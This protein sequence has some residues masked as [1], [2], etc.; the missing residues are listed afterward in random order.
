MSKLFERLVAARGLDEAFLSPKYE[1]CLDPYLL[2]QMREAVERIKFAVKNHEKCLIYGDYDVDGVT[3]STVLYDALRLAGIDDIEIMLPNRFVDGYGMSIKVV[4]RAI[5]DGAKLVLTVDCGSRNHDIVA[6]LRKN[7][8]DVVV[9]DHHECEETLPDALAVVNPK[10]KDAEKYVKMALEGSN[11]ASK[12]FMIKKAVGELRELA[13]AGVAFKI[14]QALMQE[15][16]IPEGQEKWLLDLATIGTIC[17]S[18]ILQGE[19]RRICKYGM[20]VLE[21]TRR[22]GLKE[23]MMRAGVKK[24][25]SD[26]IGYQ[27]GPRLNAA[28]RMDTAEKA[29]NLLMSKRRAEA[30]LLATELENLNDQRKHQQDSAVKEIAVRGVGENPVIIEQGDWHEGVLGIIAGRLVEEYHRPAFVLGVNSGELK[31]SGRSFGD[32]SLAEALE[33]C[34]GQIIGGGGHAAAC[35]LR[36]KMEQLDGFRA[37][38][39]D[40]YRSLNLKNQER[41]LEAREDVSVGNFED[42]SLELMD[43]IRLLEPFGEGNMMPIFRLPGVR[44]MEVARL[45]AGKQHLRL[46]LWDQFDHGLKVMKFSAPEDYLRLCP[47]DVVDAWV[48]L[49]ENVFRGI[50]SVEGRIVR[51]VW[52]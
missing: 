37:A 23:L 31:G 52:N 5:S 40:Y 13:G 35:G 28:G 7:G 45:G 46:L 14:A 48:T 1:E 19:N 22:P 32:F 41:Y 18:M 33:A 11:L 29:L 42:F 27:I 16:L 30:A 20:L 26:A 2:P 9:T 50:R 39:N 47:G 24:L 36:L 43:E 8:V 38:V 51:L 17:D 6:E 34:R 15:G 49:E 10:R 44:V 12:E 21:K 3:A 25:S 4:Q